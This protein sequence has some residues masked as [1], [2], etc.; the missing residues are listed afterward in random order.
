MRDVPGDALD[1]E[2]RRCHR[3][4][5]RALGVDVPQP[6]GQG[7]HV[8]QHR[9]VAFGEIEHLFPLQAEAHSHPDPVLGVGFLDAD[10]VDQER[11]RVIVLD[12]DQGLGKELGK[13]VDERINLEYPSLHLRDR[14]LGGGHASRPVSIQEPVPIGLDVTV[15]R[16][17]PLG[18]SGQLIHRS[19]YF[20]SVL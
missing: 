19:H 17:H 1:G 12:L 7:L 15:Q 6:V 20:S 5:K 13:S 10:I 9:P 4:G 3:L 18:V 2:A 11:T 14:Q 8:P 16:I